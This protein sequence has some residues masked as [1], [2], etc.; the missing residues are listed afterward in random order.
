MT[1]SNILTFHVGTARTVGSYTQLITATQHR[2]YDH[3]VFI[4]VSRLQVQFLLLH[5]SVLSHFLLEIPKLFHP[6]PVQ[7]SDLIFSF[8]HLAPP[9]FKGVLKT[10]KHENDSTKILT[11]CVSV[12]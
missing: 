9:L 5:K 1:T 10:S 6:P 7:I 11:E 4:K 2:E 3:L 8:P 12:R